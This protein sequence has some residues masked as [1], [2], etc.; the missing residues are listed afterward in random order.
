MRALVN[1]SLRGIR[2]NKNRW[3]VE[4]EE[5]L[6]WVEKR[7]DSDRTETGDLPDNDRS[8]FAVTPDTVSRLATAETE[9]RMLREQLD[10]TRAERD[11][12]SKLLEKALEPRPRSIGW[13]DRLLGRS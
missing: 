10:E 4:E 2:D 11:R 1:G 12:L 13:F 9:A 5:A 7:P 8:D 6:R 3:K